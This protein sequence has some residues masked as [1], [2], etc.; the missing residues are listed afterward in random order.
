MNVE[1]ILNGDYH[2]FLCVKNNNVVMGFGDLHHY[3]GIDVKEKVNDD[4]MLNGNNFFLNVEN[5]FLKMRVFGHHDG[6]GTVEKMEYGGEILNWDDGHF[7]SMENVYVKMACCHHHD[8][9]Y[10]ILIVNGG[11][12]ESLN[13][14]HDDVFFGVGGVMKVNDGNEIPNGNDEFC[15]AKN[16]DL[17]LGES[18]GGYGMENESV[19]MN[20]GDHLHG[21]DLDCSGHEGLVRESGF[22]VYSFL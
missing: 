12:G 19:M 1:E 5:C 18:C 20:Y 3:D 2:N 13:V 22:S 6:G 8:G 15:Y 17:G 9:G 4:L 11:D 14:E 21:S 16:D 7:Q 10:V